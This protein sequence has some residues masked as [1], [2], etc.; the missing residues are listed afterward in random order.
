MYFPLKFIFCVSRGQIMKLIPV[1]RFFCSFLLLCAAA[2]VLQPVMAE[3]GTITIGYR[4]SGGTYIG[5]TIIF[6][7]KNTFGDT[8]L[9]KITGPGLPSE[10]V[11]MN[12]LN[13]LF[14]TAT[15]VGVDQDGMWKFVW[16]ASNVPGLEKMQTAVYTFTAT[17]SLNPRESAKTSLLLKRPDFSIT[18][19]PNPSNP[20]DYIELTGTTGHDITSVKIEIT[21]ASGKVLHSFTSPVG[22]SG[23]LS[24]NF[25]GDMGPGQYT[26]T[27]SNPSLKTPY[28]TVMSVVSPGGLIPVVTVMTRVQGSALPTAEMTGEVTPAPASE[29]SPA[30]SPVAPLTILTALTAGVVI[31]G[32]SRRS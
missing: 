5:D 27:V 20:G 23:D 16:Y 1:N 2:C 9:L 25:H 6:D 12:N 8:T 21:E 15:S 28:R 24:Y 30:K 14:G 3:A 19:S 7:G 10:G 32:I 17:D 26:V 22:S 4:G 31:A 29:T 18:V 13:G 11:P